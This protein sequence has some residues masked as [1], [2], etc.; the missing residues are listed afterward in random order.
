MDVAVKS[1]PVLIYTLIALTPPHITSSLALTADGKRRIV[2]RGW[3]QLENRVRGS[4]HVVRAETLQGKLQ[5]VILTCG[6]V[7]REE[8]SAPK[9]VVG[10]IRSQSTR[11]ILEV[12]VAA[13]VIR[14]K[15]CIRRITVGLPGVVSVGTKGVK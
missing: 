10:A 8:R 11:S 4:L 1:L 7:L 3:I 13:N 6:A 15:W 14:S 2:C 9:V 5:P 12:S